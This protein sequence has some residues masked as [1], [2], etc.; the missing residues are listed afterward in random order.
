MNVIFPLILI[1]SI[2]FSFFNS[3]EALITALASG[4]EKAV[5]LSLTLLAVY[6]VWSGL[7]NVLTKSGATQKLSNLIK[8]PIKKLFN[9]NDD[10][11][12]TQLSLNVT[13]N[14]L[15]VSGISTPAGIEAMKLLDSENNDH[16]K[17]LL[18]V[19]SSTSIQILPVSVL[20]LLSVYG[21]SPGKVIIVTII[22]TAFSTAAGILLCKVFK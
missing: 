19:I 12:A 4:G 17:T 15:G 9:T 3:P 13:A 2:I 5:K 8:A 14:A 21:G 20:Q 6:A 22:S 11:I 18:T 10:N 1:F 7:I 16:A